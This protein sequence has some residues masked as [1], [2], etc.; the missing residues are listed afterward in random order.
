MDNGPF[1]MGNSAGM[2]RNTGGRPAPARPAERRVEQP[3]EPVPEPASPVHHREPAHR[4]AQPPQS[5]GRNRKLLAG[6]IVAIIALA[7]IA[8]WLWTRPGVGDGID[9]GKYQAVFFTNGQVYFGKLQ[10]FNDDYMKLTDIYYLQTQ[11]AGASD[12]KNPQKTSNDQNDVQLIK[13]GDEIHGPE[14]EMLIA[15]DQMLFYENLKPG[16]KVAESIKKH[17][18]EK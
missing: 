6:V 13:L 16:G 11:T 9:A 5:N 18:N 14:D 2:G 15:K 10:A 12:A 3:A 17:K 4:P 8:G 7:A 1:R